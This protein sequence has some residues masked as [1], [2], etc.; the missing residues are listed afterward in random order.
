MRQQALASPAQRK[1]SAIRD[2]RHYGVPAI[3]DVTLLAGL[4]L[5]GL[6]AASALTTLAAEKS[7][8]WDRFDSDITVNTDGT[9]D[10]AE[11]QAIRFVDGSLALATATSRNRTSRISAMDDYRCFR[12]HLYP[13]RM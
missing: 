10:V 4:L 8:V 6:F 9:F 13:G 7:I 12:Q 1:P 11:H 5:A 2:W 3:F